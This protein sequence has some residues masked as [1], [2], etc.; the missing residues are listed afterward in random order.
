[1]WSDCLENK[2][3]D[4]FQTGGMNKDLEVASRGAQN[5]GYCKKCQTLLVH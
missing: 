3:C 1:M 5:T 2:T 4:E